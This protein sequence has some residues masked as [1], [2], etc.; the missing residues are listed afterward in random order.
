VFGDYVLDGG[1]HPVLTGAYQ[2]IKVPMA[3][4]GITRASP[5]QLAM[6][7]WYG[8]AGTISIDSISFSN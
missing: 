6:G 2:D 5:G 3:A 7:F 1:G 8:G 4:N